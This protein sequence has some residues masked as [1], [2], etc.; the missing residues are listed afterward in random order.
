M[1]YF[2]RH[3]AA[4]VNGRTFTIHSFFAI[5][6]SRQR[7]RGDEVQYQ[8]GSSVMSKVYLAMPQPRVKFNFQFQVFFTPYPHFHFVTRGKIMSHKMRVGSVQSYEAIGYGPGAA[9]INSLK[10]EATYATRVLCQGVPDLGF[11]RSAPV[12]AWRPCLA[13]FEHL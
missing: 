5:F 3:Q 9:S 12:L 11:L 10:L 13:R 8:Y 4:S 6:R 7:Q 1:L 2:H